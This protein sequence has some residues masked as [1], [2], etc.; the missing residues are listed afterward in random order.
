MIFSLEVSSA[1]ESEVR[2]VSLK[3]LMT[4]ISLVTLSFRGKWRQHL[5]FR[6]LWI[7]RIFAAGFYSHHDHEL[8]CYTAPSAVNCSVSLIMQA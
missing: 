6:D 4:S 5:K 8:W 2:Q 3:Q 7:H 1:L